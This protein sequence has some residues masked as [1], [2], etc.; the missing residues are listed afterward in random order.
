MQLIITHDFICV[1]VVNPNLTLS[2]RPPVA[3]WMNCFNTANIIPNL[4]SMLLNV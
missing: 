4:D 3:N 2:C 1:H